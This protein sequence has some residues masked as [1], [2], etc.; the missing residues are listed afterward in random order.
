MYVCYNIFKVEEI[1]SNSTS[2]QAYEGNLNVDRHLNLRKFSYM[3][4]RKI[5]LGGVL[6]KGATKIW[7][8]QAHV[9]WR[10]N[11]N[12]IVSAPGHCLFVYFSVSLS[13]FNG[14]SMHSSSSITPTFYFKEQLYFL[15]LRLLLIGLWEN[16]LDRSTW[17][18]FLFNSLLDT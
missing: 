16:E 12:T 17:W 15:L 8:V 13:F 4:N 9:H 6:S 2:I 5:Q 1:Q 14:R 11:E 7:K 10:L 18:L 3:F